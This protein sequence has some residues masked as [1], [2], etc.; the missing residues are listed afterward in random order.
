MSTNLDSSSDTANCVDVGQNGGD[1]DGDA[2]EQDDEE[3]G[4]SEDENDD[5]EDN[6]DV[7][8]IRCLRLIF[9]I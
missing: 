9:P 3:N 5:A 1:G 2:E 4:D 6:G 7:Y 8:D